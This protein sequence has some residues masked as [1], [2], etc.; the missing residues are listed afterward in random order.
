MNEICMDRRDVIDTCRVCVKTFQF[1]FLL[2]MTL[3]MNGEEQKKKGSTMMFFPEHTSLDCTILERLG[4]D[5]NTPRMYLSS[6]ICNMFR[7]VHSELSDAYSTFIVC[8]QKRLDELES[9][10]TVVDA[11]QEKVSLL[12]NDA[13]IFT[14]RFEE[15]NSRA[16]MI[17]RQ[18]SDLSVVNG[19]L[20][21][22]ISAYKAKRVKAKQDLADRDATIAA[23][24]ENMADY[25]RR[26]V[27]CLADACISDTS[28]RVR[29]SELKASNSRLR[30]RI[31]LR[32]EIYKRVVSSLKRQVESLKNKWGDWSARSGFVGKRCGCKA[33]IQI[34]SELVL[35]SNGLLLRQPA[36][37]LR[38]E[39]SLIPLPIPCAWKF[40]WSVWRETTR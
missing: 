16:E 5:D 29:L 22:A 40:R 30:H 14:Q 15:L 13:S 9:C 35:I 2:C 7:H 34:T 21:E 3:R 39:R 28:N 36:P 1:F 31:N 18:A 25:D 8:L 24:R 33:S 23:L 19:Q 17:G 11:L 37:R 38:F 20:N 32:D 26:L 6:Y 4:M 12:K 27:N 10:R